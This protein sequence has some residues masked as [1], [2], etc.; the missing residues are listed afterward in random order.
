MIGASDRLQVLRVMV[1]PETTER[2]VASWLEHSTFPDVAA[3]QKL[4]WETVSVAFAVHCGA[5]PVN[6]MAPL[7]AAEKFT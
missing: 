3:S 5:V 2:G 4:R 1:S 6:A 7:E